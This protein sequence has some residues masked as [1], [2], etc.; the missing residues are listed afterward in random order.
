VAGPPAHRAEEHFI[1]VPRT[2]QTIAT[3]HC[4]GAPTCLFTAIVTDREVLRTSTDDAAKLASLKFL[5]HWVSDIHQPLHVSFADDRGG[6]VIRASGACAR[7]L[8]AVWDVCLVAKAFGSDP[9]MAAR[10]LLDGVPERDKAAWLAAPLAGWADES[11][12]ITRRPSVGYCVLIGP[13]CVY[14]AGRESF[15]VGEEEKAVVVNATYLDQHAAVVRDRL[16]QAGIRL[17]HLLNTT[18]GQ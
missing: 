8:H 18:L 17:A 7:N 2:L 6:N 15:A 1:N 14:Q 10:Q 5:R 12:E 11:Y 3:A 9:A 4:Q 13:A 16:K